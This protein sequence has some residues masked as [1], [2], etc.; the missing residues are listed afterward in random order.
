MARIEKRINSKG[1]TSWRVLI[2]L[3]GHPPT[4]GTFKKRQDAI[5]WAKIT[6]TKILEGR[7]FKAAESR[8]RTLSELIERFKTDELSHRRKDADKVIAHLEW[9]EARLGAYFLGDLTPI[10]I[11]ELKPVLQ[12]EKTKR[13]DRRSNQTVN[14]YISSL[15]ICF[16]YAVRE[17]GWVDDNPVLKVRK[18]T[19][20]KGRE[21]FLSE[22][23]QK[24]LLAAAK[25][26]PS[27]LILPFVQL[28]LSTGMRLSEITTLQWRHVDL[29]RRRIILE[30]TKNGDSRTVSLA[31]PAYDIIRQ[32]SKAGRIGKEFVFP[33]LTDPSK[34]YNPRK[35][36]NRIIKKAKLNDFRIH[37][38]RHSAASYLAMEG[39]THLEI[40]QILGH[41]TLQMVKRYSHFTIDHT[42]AVLERMNARRFADKQ[43][44]EI[45]CDAGEQSNG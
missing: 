1:E 17:L 29:K 23:E 42:A 11:S 22:D 21:R 4:S 3:K 41:K 35:A 36:W 40:A 34:P 24:R 13:S 20:P 38:L 16:S 37:D 26:D 10:R 5:D 14:R 19:E 7:W 44:Q 18:L 12:N 6:E 45:A 15:S 28:A 33:Q 30:E 39:A 2:R 9:W 25:D 32:A 8:R 31:K 27:K 43:S